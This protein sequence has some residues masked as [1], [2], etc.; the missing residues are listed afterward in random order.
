MPEVL[1]AALRTAIDCPRSQCP[2]ERSV[3]VL[4]AAAND[5]V[6]RPTIVVQHPRYPRTHFELPR[7]AAGYDR[8]HGYQRAVLGNSNDGRRWYSYPVMLACIMEASDKILDVPLVILQEERFRW[9]AAEN[10]TRS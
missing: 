4:P 1:V 8:S 6:F 3:Y 9:A 7:L 2:R 10:L 5:I